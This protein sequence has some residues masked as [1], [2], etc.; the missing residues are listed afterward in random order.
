MDDQHSPLFGHHQKPLNHKALEDLGADALEQAQW[1]FML[2]DELKDLDEALEGLALPCRRRVRLL[3]DLGHD[4]GL[5]GNGSESLGHGA[6]SW[7][8]LLASKL[9]EKSQRGRQNVPNASQGERV[10][11]FGKRMTLSLS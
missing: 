5:C 6:E 3:A 10:F 7:I 2:N 9:G 1:S 4:Q 8:S 11:L